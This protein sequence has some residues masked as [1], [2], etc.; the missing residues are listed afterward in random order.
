MTLSLTEAANGGNKNITLTATGRRRTLKVTIPKGVRPGQRIRLTGQGG[1]GMAGGGPGDL[2]L[3]V[4]LLPD[5][6]FRLDD[7]NL[8]ATVNVTPWV[9]ALGGRAKVSTLDGDVTIKVPPG[10]SSGRKIRLRG[11]GFPIASGGAGDLIAEIRIAVPE[12]LTER[13]RELFESLAK[14]STFEPGT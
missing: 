12:T 5:P 4:D 8:R 10:S 6:R 2:Y 9:A 13:E 3:T 11:K 1:P 7:D 14:D